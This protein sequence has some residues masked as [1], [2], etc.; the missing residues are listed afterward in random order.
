[1]KDRFELDDDEQ[2]IENEIDNYVAAGAETRER[3][4]G[5][6]EKARKRKNVNIRISG[7]VLD[8]LRSRAQREGIPYQTLIA[9]VLHKYVTDQLVDERDIRK[10]LE[11]VS[12]GDQE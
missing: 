8:Q 9:S 7:F 10:A 6:L 3:V 2:S 11:V 1:M 4:E 5:I 12:A